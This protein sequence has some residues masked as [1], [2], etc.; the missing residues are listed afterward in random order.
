[1]KQCTVTL[2]GR[3]LPARVYD[4]VVV[5]TG[6]AGFNAADRLHHYGRTDIAI[7][8]DYVK[9]GTSRNTGSDKQTYYKL[10][11]SGNEPDSVYIF[12]VIEEIDSDTD[13]Y[14]G[15][16]SQELVDEI[17]AVFMEK[18]KDDFNFID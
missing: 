2:N 8:T 14:V 7:V 10:T 3:T 4:A 5:G 16:E 12:E 13:T 11:L 18:H 1:M 9:G 15:I 6:C 17:Y